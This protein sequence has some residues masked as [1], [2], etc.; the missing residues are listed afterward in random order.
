ME[1]VQ[2]KR[3]KRSRGGKPKV[4]LGQEAI[5]LHKRLRGKIEIRS[6]VSARSPH[7]ISIAYTPGV[8]EVCLEIAAD[9]QK[10]YEY[11]SKWNNV[12]IVTDGTR[13]LGLGSLGPEA[14]LPVMEG[15]AVLY[16]Q[17]GH[18]DA[19]P[20]CLHTTDADEIVKTIKNISPVFGG[21]NIEDMETPKVLEIVDRLTEELDIPVF[22]DDQHGTAVVTLAA[23]LNALRLTKR[24]PEDTSVLVAGAGSAGYGI[25]KI[26]YAIGIRDMV[27]TDSQ[28]VVSKARAPETMNRYKHELA[29]ITH[30]KEGVT[31]LADAVKGRDVFVG[32]SGVKKLLTAEMVRSMNKDSIIFPLTNPDP[33]IHP[34]EAFGA[35]AKVIATGS[36]KF[37]NR[38]N[39]AL[40]F[41]FTMRAILDNRIRRISQQLLVNVAYALADLISKDKLSPFNVVPDVTDPRIQEAV[42]KAVRS[43]TG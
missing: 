40:V 29:S 15:K 41:P 42:N 2:Q 31:T 16:K 1:T 18:V 21:I 28:G 6:K 30:P 19:F 32:V 11:T 38:A 8:A 13:T 39:N 20:I 22:H 36:Y 26:L 37:E 10:A 43:A 27:V 23:L 12:A 25:A 17:F 14:A 33:E 4:T 24:K 3:R 9:R 7:E 5:E 34:K 35:G